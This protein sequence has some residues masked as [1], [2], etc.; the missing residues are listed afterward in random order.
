[1]YVS[2]IGFHVQVLLQLELAYCHR[3]GRQDVRRVLRG[4]A[5]L[6]WQHF[7]YTALCLAFAA[8][9]FTSCFFIMH[10]GLEYLLANFLEPENCLE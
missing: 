2:L 10:D 6:L 1:M 7:G 3:R 9:L 8:T 5:K 4:G